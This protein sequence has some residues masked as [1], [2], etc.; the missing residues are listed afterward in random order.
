MFL[1]R[2]FGDDTPKTLKWGIFSL[3]VG[4]SC[5]ERLAAGGNVVVLER[6]WVP[7]LAPE[8]GDSSLTVLNATMRRIDLI[9]KVLAPGF[10]T[11]LPTIFTAIKATAEHSIFWSVVVVAIMSLLSPWVEWTL[12]QRVWNQSELLQ[13]PKSREQDVGLG[14]DEIKV[15]PT[16][17]TYLRQKIAG[18][19]RFCRSDVLLP[20]IS[21]ALLYLSVLTFSS[22]MI[23]F[24]LNSG[25]SLPVVT[26]SRLCSSL[27]EVSATAIMPW[28]VQM[29]RNRDSQIHWAPI[30]EE[31]VGFMED[32]QPIQTNRDN[33]EVERVGLWALWW[34]NLMLI[35]AFYG[36]IGLTSHETPSLLG[37]PFPLFSLPLLMGVAFSRIGL[38]TFD[39][40]Y[41]QLQQTLPPPS[42]RGE[43]TG[44]EQ[45]FT[46]TASLIQW[47][48]TAI[49]SQPKDFHA[50][51]ATSC[52][53][54]FS[55][56]CCYSWFMRKRRG[57]LLHVKVSDF[58]KN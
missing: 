3:I 41:S 54:V 44:I 22:P 13:A 2:L 6:D 43:F 58:F 27:L 28:A 18:L 39:L 40:A 52:M 48:L 55:S 7:T 8:F 14:V 32:S 15:T 51:A 4:L 17:N 16:F 31:D 12:A 45:S 1:L 50:L 5:I 47:T 26:I 9:C 38:W 33:A 23:T 10:V 34:M 20:T 56:A 57:H 42:L 29:L 46:S 24:L 49:I 36:V 25:F 21:I 11:L 37:L 19:V 35:P 30:N 53:A